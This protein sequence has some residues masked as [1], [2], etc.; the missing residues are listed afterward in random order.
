VI[1][2]SPFHPVLRLRMSGAIPPLLL[3]AITASTDTTLLFL[4]KFTSPKSITAVGFELSTVVLFRYL[5]LMRSPCRL[6]ISDRRFGGACCLHLQCLCSCVLQCSSSD[7]CVLFVT[8]Q[9]KDACLVGGIS[10]Y[11]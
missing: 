8:W 10:W 7:N 11:S 5:F 3:C 9:T 4:R 2:A 6:V 1:L